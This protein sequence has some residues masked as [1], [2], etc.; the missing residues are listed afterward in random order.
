VSP[1]VDAGELPPCPPMMIAVGDNEYLRDEIRMSNLEVYLTVVYFA[2][3]FA[4]NGGKVRLQNY[5]AMPH[6]FQMF[7]KHPSPK[8]SFRE[9]AKFITEVTSGKSI[10]TEFQII[11]GKGIIEGEPLQIETY[12]I[13]FTKEEVLP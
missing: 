6:V 3:Q 11:N 7:L 8:T 1:V 10:E 13:S 4:K 5:L 9:F 2:S 12:Q